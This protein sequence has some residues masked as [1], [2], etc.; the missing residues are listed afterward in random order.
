[1][2]TDNLKV[3]AVKGAGVNVAAQFIGFFFHTAG[4][5]VLARL[6]LPRDFGLVTMVTVFSMWFMNFGENG[7]TEY[8]IQKKNIS[9]KEV[10]SVFWLHIIIASLLAIIFTFFAFF[11]VH[12]YSEPALSGIGAIMASGFIFNALYTCRFAIL[13]REMKF[14]SIAIIELTAIILSNVLSVTAAIIGMGYWAIVIRQMALPVVT[15]IGAS[16]LNPLP[17]HRPIYLNNTLTALKYAIQVYVNFSLGYLT[18]NID[19]VLLGKFHGSAVLGNYDRAYHLSTMPANQLLTPLHNV[20]LATLSKLIQDRKQFSVYYI[21]AV[22]IVAFAGSGVTVVLMLTAQDLVQLLLGP[23]WSE[24]GK[25]LVA[26][27]PGIAAMLVYGTHS[28]L[29]LSLGK[30]DRWLRWNIFVTLLTIVVFIIALPYGAVAMGLAYSIR[31]YIILAPGLWY[32]GRPIQLRLRTLF[33]S[34]WVYF[35]SG[36]FICVF[37]LYI[38][39]YWQPLSGFLVRLSLINKVIIIACI[40]SLLYIF[41]IVIIE[42]SFKS[43][44]KVLSLIK[45]FLSYK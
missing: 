34:V 45:I 28:W 4:V 39:T 21:K 25:V 42:R 13:K 5:I 2:T 19:K 22:S 17:L 10:N 33:Y 1:M 27:S 20:A 15:Y 26:L 6:L 36:I 35:F 37:W 9:R 40:V 38:S 32:A 18:K 3:M 23:A 16:F 24:A 12:F 44:F 30:P 31:A 43:I 29:H 8:L 7:F 41:L 11:L 14:A